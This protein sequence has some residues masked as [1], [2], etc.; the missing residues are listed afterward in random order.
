MDIVLKHLRERSHDHSARSLADVQVLQHK[1]AEMWIA[2]EKTRRLVYHAAQL[3]DLGEPNATA[4]IMAAKAD[5]GDTSVWIANE[6]MTLGGGIAYRENSM[7]ARL[8]RDARASHVMSPTT[9][10]LKVWLGRSLLGL[11][12]L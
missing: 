11:P 5:A 2:V 1:V 9:D 8:L 12:L 4:A 6:A 10:I 3:G 7:L